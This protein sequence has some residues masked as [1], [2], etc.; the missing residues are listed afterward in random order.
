MKGTSRL[1]FLFEFLKVAVLIC[2]VLV[3]FTNVSYSY[4]LAWMLRSTSH[5]IREHRERFLLTTQFT[6]GAFYSDFL[7]WQYL[8]NEVAECLVVRHV[9]VILITPLGY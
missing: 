9:A 3:R 2:I 4:I 1:V 7:Q 5:T 8:T 6:R